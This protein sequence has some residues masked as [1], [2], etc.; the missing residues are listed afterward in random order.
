MK[1]SAFTLIEL[2][3]VMVIVAVLAAIT[4]PLV[5][6][7][8]QATRKSATRATIAKIDAALRRMS[9]RFDRQFYGG[10]GYTSE[11]YQEFGG[12]FQPAN[13]RHV[14]LYKK[15]FREKFYPTTFPV[16]S[17]AD[18]A[19][20]LY[21]IVTTNDDGET[22]FNASEIGDTDG[23]GKL[24]FIDAWGNPIR[25]YPYASRL[26]RPDGHGTPIDTTAARVVAGSI[27][28]GIED[29]D[30]QFG[31]LTDPVIL[32]GLGFTPASFE[33][34]YHTLGTYHPMLVLSAGNDG[35]PGLYEPHDTTN[36]GH[37]G[38]LN[39]LDAL[40]DDISNLNIRAKQ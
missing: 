15:K 9:G 18:S 27:P 33:A 29:S 36:F 34:Q 14:V 38:K 28:P 26:F 25:Y 21:E 8:M 24:E 32:A 37:R 7:V 6:D 12:E 20:M 13:P 22:T 16:L 19:E 4:I 39:S 2:L 1:R 17:A 10:Y 30:D 31:M 5:G 11:F 23:D 40:H 3:V 35:V